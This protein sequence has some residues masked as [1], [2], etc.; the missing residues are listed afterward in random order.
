MGAILVGL[1]T[2]GMTLLNVNSYYQQV[3]KGVVMVVAIAFDV[4]SVKRK[5]KR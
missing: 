5:Q 1:L 4:Y 2:N 3:V